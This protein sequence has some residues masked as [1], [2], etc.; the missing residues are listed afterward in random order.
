LSNCQRSSFVPSSD[1]VVL[2][3]DRQPSSDMAAL[4]AFPRPKHRR[5]SRA[6]PN[7]DTRTDTPHTSHAKPAGGTCRLALVGRGARFGKAHLLVDRKS[8]AGHHHLIQGAAS[9]ISFLSRHAKAT[10][11]TPSRRVHTLHRRLIHPSLPILPVSWH[12]VVL[13]VSET[14]KARLP[15]LPQS[16]T[17][18]TS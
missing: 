3:V 10:A 1:V 14:L 15:R 5:R 18:G 4:R 17:E 7:N 9:S 6:N 16:P 11:T 8:V 13:L 12:A 2:G